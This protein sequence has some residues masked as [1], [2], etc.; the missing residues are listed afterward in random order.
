[1][2]GSVRVKICGLSGADDAGLAAELGA[3]FLGFIFYAKSPR[4]VTLAQYREFRDDLPP[5]PRVYVQV[6]PDAEE[7]RR[8]LDEG[9]DLFQPHFAA[10]EDR[11]IV[12]T[13]AEAVS[14][15]RL[16]LAPKI[17]PGDG[18]PEE[19]L[20]LAG[21]FLVDTYREDLFGGTGKTG[22]WEGFRRLSGKFPEKRWVLAGGLKPENIG[23]AAAVSGA[24]ILDVNSGI[25]TAPGRKDPERMRELFAALRSHAS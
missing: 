19:L 24:E 5:I 1:M 6:R 14:P 23:E 8:A 2:S 15:S 7:L 25:E 12:E 21:S 20:E 4:R 22:D 13:W 11:R 17:A 10:D 9:F 16:W 3:R 18:F